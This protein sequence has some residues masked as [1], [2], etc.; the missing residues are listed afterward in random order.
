MDLV[1]DLL[2]SYCIKQQRKF[3]LFTKFASASVLSAIHLVVKV[4]SAA[5]GARFVDI[6]SANI[7]TC[8]IVVVEK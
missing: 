4:P 6:R 3:Y 2:Y 8:F 1:Q 5:T 7:N